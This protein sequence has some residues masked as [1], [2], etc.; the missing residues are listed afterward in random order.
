MPPRL[1]E[2]LREAGGIKPLA[3]IRNLEVRRITRQGR[4]NV[5]KVNFWD[6]LQG[7]APDADI[8]LQNGDTI[9]IPTAT[10]IDPTEA[11]TIASANFSPDTITVD[12]VGEVDGPG[13]IELQPN[14]P[15]NQALLAAGGFDETRAN[16]NIVELI[17]LN[18]NGTVVT[19][20]INIDFSAG[21]NP[22]VNPILLQND[23]VIVSRSGSTKTVDSIDKFLNPVSRVF[24]ILNILN[25][26]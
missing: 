11:E 8:F 14:T 5:M 10:E 3:D 6:L 2:V 13:T 25:L 22:E 4:D 17:R 23:V 24:S 1:S 15:L 19:K 20:N 12:I 7:T 9:T 16:R 26:I 21:I 18:P